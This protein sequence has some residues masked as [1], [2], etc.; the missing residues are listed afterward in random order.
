MSAMASQ[1]T[2]LTTV[3][4][5]VYLGANQRKHQS[6][7]SLA[8]VRGNSPVTSEFPAQRASNA[9]NGSIWWRHHGDYETSE[10]INAQRILSLDVVS[11]KNRLNW[12]SVQWDIYSPVCDL[13][14]WK[15]LCWPNELCFIRA[16]N[17]VI[18]STTYMEI[19]FN[20]LIS[21]S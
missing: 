1:I 5:T 18:T 2:N 15:W 10:C 11:L 4:S 14:S 19:I 16:S 9:E 12:F 8:F 7:A 6:F 3:C 21:A 20:N 17:Y 13:S